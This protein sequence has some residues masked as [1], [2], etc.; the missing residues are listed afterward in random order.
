MAIIEVSICLID[1]TGRTVVETSIFVRSFKLTLEP[2]Q[3]SVK[4]GIP[5]ENSTWEKSSKM[6]VRY[7]LRYFL[8]F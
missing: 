2:S 1:L 4:E 5:S 7:S 3:A 8:P 6:E